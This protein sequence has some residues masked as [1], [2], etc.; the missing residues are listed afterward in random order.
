MIENISRYVEEGEWSSY[1]V[2]APPASMFEI[3]HTR[4]LRRAATD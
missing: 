2:S 3:A 4:S 1:S